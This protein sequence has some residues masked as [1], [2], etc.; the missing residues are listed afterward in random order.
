MDMIF[1]SI[2][3]FFMEYEGLALAIIFIRIVGLILI[4][5]FCLF[6][7]TLLISNQSIILVTT[8]VLCYLLIG[9]FFHFT[10]PVK[11]TIIETFLKIHKA[12]NVYIPIYIP[13]ILAYVLLVILNKIKYLK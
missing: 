1:S 12:M 7:T 13:F 5:P 4:F 6:M 11:E 9:C 3:Y 10:S 2:L 8:F